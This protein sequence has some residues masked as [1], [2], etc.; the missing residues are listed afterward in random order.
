M[1][2]SQDNDKLSLINKLILLDSLDKMVKSLK[3][4]LQ[5]EV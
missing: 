1:G 5:S 4:M 3:F 2:L